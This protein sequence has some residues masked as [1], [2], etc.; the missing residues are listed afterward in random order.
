[1]EPLTAK[2]IGNEIRVARKA[3]DLTQQDIQKM[4]GV[5][6]SRLSEYEC[7][8]KVPS[9]GT[10]YRINQAVHGALEHLLMIAMRQ[11]QLREKERRKTARARQDSIFRRAQLSK[12][13]QRKFLRSVLVP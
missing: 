5:G 4:T 10:L 3:A 7:G 1:M 2:E 12:R 11:H 13:Q 8:H 9:I 6:F